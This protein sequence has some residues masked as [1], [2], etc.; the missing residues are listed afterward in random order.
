LT[1][2][3]D[4]W[5]AGAFVAC[6]ATPTD[7]DPFTADGSLLVF[8]AARGA[9]LHDP[10][11]GRPVDTV[12]PRLDLG[13]YTY[14][15]L[16]GGARVVARPLIA[17]DPV[18]VYDTSSGR[19][20][21]GLHGPRAPAP[22][23]WVESPDATRLVT[24]GFG[25][26]DRI[27]LDGDATSWL[28]WE[29]LPARANGTRA[30]LRALPN[31]AS[32][33]FSR[34][35]SRLLMLAPGMTEWILV[36]AHTGDVLRRE[37]A[38]GPVRAIAFNRTNLFYVWHGRPAESGNANDR[39]DVYSAATGER[40]RGFDR[41]P[42]MN[43]TAELGSDL[44]DD[45]RHFAYGHPIAGPNVNVAGLVVADATDG[46]TLYTADRF[47]V[48]ASPQFL[49]DSPRYLAV[50]A[51]AQRWAIYGVTDA[52]PL[53]F[54]PI[55]NRPWYKRWS[56]SPDGRT[57][58]SH[59]TGGF[60]LF[61]PAGWD[62]PESTLGVLA[63]PQTW[64]VVLSLAACAAS[65]ARD[66]RRARTGAAQRQPPPA[67]TVGL[68]VVAATLTAH[69]AVTAALG[70]W[71]LTPAPL[72]LVAGLGSMTHSRA[73]RGLT[74]CL[75]AATLPWTLYLLHGVNRAGLAGRTTYPLFDRHYAVPHAAAFIALAA[76]AALCA[77]GIYLLCRRPR[78]AGL[79]T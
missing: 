72:L 78:P 29:L 64:L 4:P 53:A 48:A 20:I 75:L 42:R 55:A 8:D 61:R 6:D 28:L 44:S 7:A 73:W 71:T 34:D 54:I 41:P 24:P 62:C 46:R 17:G 37:T 19:E 39:V 51:D 35:G 60:Q 10:A 50:D 40:L 68:L 12:L 67:L 66:A 2:R 23:L 38:A 18:R 59:E 5:R 57:I 69:F 56:F 26:L 14:R 13:M 79:A 70:R 36:D 33:K 31:A 58:A 43:R 1:L 47:R 77:L 16:H 3:H 45:G 21:A 25:R 22:Q 30:P 76:A 74:L 65:L 52:R 49:P 9:T 27:A 63:F 11:T 15:A 32:F